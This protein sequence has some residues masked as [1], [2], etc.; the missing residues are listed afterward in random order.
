VGLIPFQQS[1]LTAGVDPVKFYD[2]RAVGLPVLSTSFGE[3]ALRGR[4]DGVYF[5]DRTDDLAALVGAALGHCDDVAGLRQFRDENN[6]DSR[7]RQ[8]TYFRTLCPASRIRCA[9]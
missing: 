1:E 4:N 2:Y 5:L 6:W 8:A 7:F 3:M 9:A